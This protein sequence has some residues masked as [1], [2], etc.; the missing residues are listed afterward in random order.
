MTI[1]EITAFLRE[2]SAVHKRRADAA[3]IPEIQLRHLAA[4]G[5]LLDA[6]IELMKREDNSDDL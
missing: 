5:A 1:R 6:C 3:T 4:E 2:Q